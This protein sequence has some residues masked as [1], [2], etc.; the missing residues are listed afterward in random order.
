MTAQGDRGYLKTSGDMGVKLV[1]P[2]SGLGKWK[3]GGE[4]F[5]LVETFTDADWSA[6]KQHRKSTS[7]AIHFVNGS[8]VYASSRSQ[9][10]VSLSSAESELHSMV[11]GCSDGIYIRRCLEFLTG[12]EVDHI[13]S[14]LTTV[15]QGSWCPNRGLDASDTSVGSCCGYKTWCSASNW[16]LAR[17]PRSGTTVT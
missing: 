10:V 9:R 5:W 13:T 7:T 16:Q 6:N 11:S 8:F 17:F 2:E 12:K 1:V 14:G 15:R 4:Q 3:S